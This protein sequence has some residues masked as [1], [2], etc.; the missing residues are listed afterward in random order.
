MKTDDDI[1][2]SILE[3]RK[4]ESDPKRFFL[5]Y[6]PMEIVTHYNFDDPKS[7]KEFRDARLRMDSPIM[8]MGGCNLHPEY[9]E[10]R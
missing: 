7:I 4:R 10:K 2:D 5:A 6:V 9:L 1:F 8:D 3:E